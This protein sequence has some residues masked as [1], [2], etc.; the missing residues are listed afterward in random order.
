MSFSPERRKSRKSTP[1]YLQVWQRRKR[2][3]YSSI[4]TLLAR[5]CLCVR[6]AGFR[7]GAVRAG[8][9]QPSMARNGGDGPDK[10]AN[11][12]QNL[13]NGTCHP[14]NTGRSSTAT[15]LMEKQFSL[16]RTASKEQFPI[17]RRIAGESPTGSSQYQEPLYDPITFIT[18]IVLKNLPHGSRVICVNGRSVL[19]QRWNWSRRYSCR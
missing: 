16:N 17:S 5:A 15:I 2:F 14:A 6:Q 12:P 18:R 1:M 11:A 3:R 8:Q 10:P 13:Q 19:G 4:P 9:A 7:R